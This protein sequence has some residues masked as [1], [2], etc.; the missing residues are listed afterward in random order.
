MNKKIISTLMAGSILLSFASCSKTDAEETTSATTE[1]T[2]ASSD[3]TSK[4]TTEETTKATDASTVS[5][6]EG[7]IYEVYVTDRFDE[8]IEDGVYRVSNY[9]FGDDLSTVTLDLYM[10]SYLTHEE[11]D[12]LKSGDKIYVGCWADANF[13]GLF[14]VGEM[15]TLDNF[16]FVSQESG[17]TLIE[18][19]DGLFYIN[20]GM[21]SM[22]TDLYEEQ[23]TLK[24]SPDLKIVDNAYVFGKDGI[25]TDENSYEYSSLQEFIDD[26]NS[27]SI[28]T[29]PDLHVVV[30]DEVITE[31]YINPDLHEPWKE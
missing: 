29:I 8:S 23:A 30:K 20:D 18:Q 5:E 21:G 6:D 16:I 27:D 25:K 9:T 13:D 28:Y 15:E 11:V 22:A 3:E 2:V 14:D 17:L 31:I 12:N 1:A 10:Y 26:L 4:E 24:L 7:R 19:A